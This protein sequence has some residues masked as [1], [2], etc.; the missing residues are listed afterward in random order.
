MI[1]IYGYKR[2]L[3]SMADKLFDKKSTSLADKP[4]SSSGIKNEN[5]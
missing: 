3:A 1:K 4:A 5:I 2:G